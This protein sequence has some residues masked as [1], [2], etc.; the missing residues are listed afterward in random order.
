MKRE[1]LE[2]LKKEIETLTTGI[3]QKQK[4]LN[5]LNSFIPYREVVEAIEA[6]R[7]INAKIDVLEKDINETEKSVTARRERLKVYNEFKEKNNVLQLKEIELSAISENLKALDEK[8][9]LINDIDSCIKGKRI[10]SKDELNRFKELNTKIKQLESSLES[11]AVMLDIEALI[12]IGVIISDTESVLRSGQSHQFEIVNF[13][14]KFSIKDVADIT[15]TNR[16][17]SVASENLNRCKQ[18]IKEMIDKFST[19]LTGELEERYSKNSEREMLSVEIK[20]LLQGNTIEGIRDKVGLFNS[21]IKDIK[22]AVDRLV[23]GIGDIKSLEVE[24]TV[25]EEEG[26]R[27]SVKKKD[28]EGH[29]IKK[30]KILGKDAE[31]DL[32][33]TKMALELNLTEMEITDMEKESLITLSLTELKNKK[34]EISENLE[35]ITKMVNDNQVMRA[36]L[37]GEL[38][39]IPSYEELVSVEEKIAE[40]QRRKEKAD[41]LFESL[42]VLEENIKE[43]SENTRNFINTKINESSSRHFRTLTCEKYDKVEILLGDGISIQVRESGQDLYRE[44]TPGGRSLSTGALQ[45]LYFAVR[46]ALVDILTGDRRLPLILDD[47]FVDFDSYRL[48]EAI[49]ILRSLTTEGYQCL[50]FTCHEMMAKDSGTILTL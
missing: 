21:G 19:L 15:V 11:Q 33:K 9:R 42:V 45:Q 30:A 4:I 16:G 6:L 48:K 39:N 47:P 3:G 18:Q 46:L 38:K 50:L 34:K 29:K 49:D 10:P 8:I 36:G 35:Q 32:I 2:R 25:L 1:K 12:D 40:L 23:K 28:L 22:E 37:E 26:K 14:E 43:A 24:E 27:L 7:N 31:E 5:W 20:R 17:L 13:K 41:I 44:I